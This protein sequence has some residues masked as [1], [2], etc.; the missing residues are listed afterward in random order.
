MDSIKKGISSPAELLSSPREDSR[1]LTGPIPLPDHNTVIFQSLSQTWR[2][3]P[4]LTKK[5]LFSSG[6][7]WSR[8]W[9]ARVWLIISDGD[10]DYSQFW[11]RDETTGISSIFMHCLHQVSKINAQMGRLSQPSHFISGTTQKM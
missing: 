6:A 10:S 3:L 1:P 8:W 2:L 4:S 9:G 5:P 11:E 7:I